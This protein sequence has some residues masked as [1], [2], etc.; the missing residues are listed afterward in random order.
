MRINVRGN[1]TA[2]K[3]FSATGPLFTA[4]STG[5]TIQPTIL[6]ATL[7]SATTIQV[8]LPVASTA[9]GTLDQAACNAIFELRGVGLSAAKSSP[10]ESCTIAANGLS[11]TLTLFSSSYTAGGYRSSN[12]IS[13]A[14]AHASKTVLP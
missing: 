6:G 11:M 2:L 8:T 10:F 5:L 13:L 9:G 3:A 1:Q 14:P 7:T 12:A 4:L